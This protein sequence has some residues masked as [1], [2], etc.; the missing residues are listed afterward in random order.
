MT[1]VFIT[2]KIPQIGIDLLKKKH[3]VRVYPKDQVIPRKELLAAVKWADGLLCMLTD[4]IDKEL[5]EI[6][7]KLKVIANYA[8]GFNNIDIQAATEKGI[9]VTNTPGVLTDAVAEH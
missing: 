6:N 4:K 9:P 8:V 2:R 5:L 1:K 3:T 7:P